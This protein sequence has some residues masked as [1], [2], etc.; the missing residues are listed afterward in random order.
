MKTVLLS[1]TLLGVCFSTWAKANNDENPIEFSVIP[2]IPNISCGGSPVDATYTVINKEDSATIIVTPKE[3]INH[4]NFPDDLVTIE[5]AT[6]SG[7]LTTCNNTYLKPGATCNINLIINPENCGSSTILG[8]IDRTL[9][10]ATGTQYKDPTAPIKFAYTTLGAADSFAILGNE[11][12]N[13]GSISSVTGSVGHTSETVPISGPFQV[14]NGQLYVSPTDQNVINANDAFLAAY[15]K[16]IDNKANC[17]LHSDITFP[18][19]LQA[20]Y[21]CLSSNQGLNE[22][23]ID[24]LIVLS[25][26]GDFVFFI[27]DGMDSCF[28]DT[29]KDSTANAACNLKIKSTTSFLYKEG[30]SKERVFWLTGE[31]SSVQIESGAE[32]DGTVFSGL[33]ISTSAQGP[34]SAS[35][36]GHLWA[37][38][39]ITLYGD[40]VA[41]P[42]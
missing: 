4:D 42:D 23:T 40:S 38:G 21:Y 7:S 3:I 12:H 9:V 32:L 13:L 26:K 33:D 16:F 37:L 41:I 20:S 11:V 22:V 2:Q 25:G 36:E 28:P 15:Q 1:A 19:E 24:G 31:G 30:A 6:S 35:V 14:T 5:P 18:T 29:T 39:D 34:S 27:D 8:P 17:R 10:V